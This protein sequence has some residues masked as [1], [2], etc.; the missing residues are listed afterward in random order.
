[1]TT[2]TR[3]PRTFADAALIRPADGR[4]LQALRQLARSGGAHVERGAICLA[5]QPHAALLAI[6][7]SGAVIAAV[8]LDEDDAA[9]LTSTS[10]TPIERAPACAQESQEAHPH[11]FQ[12]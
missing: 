6:A 5:G 1:M 9:S 4:A 12:R 8:L 10:S 11:V 7:P 3:P 2:M